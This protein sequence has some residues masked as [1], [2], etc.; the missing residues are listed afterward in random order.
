MGTFQVKVCAINNC[1]DGTWSEAFQAGIYYSPM[2]FTLSDGAGY[3]EG[4]PGIEVTLDGSETGVNYQLYRG[5]TAVGSPMA[6]TG[7]ALNFGYQ[8]EQGIYTCMGSTDHC[9]AQMV[10]NTYIYI[11]QAP[12]AAA[13]PTG[14]AQEC[15][16]NTGVAYSTAGA[17]N[18]TAY[19]WTLSP[20]AAGTITGSG[21]TATVDWADDFTGMASIAVQGINDC[22]SGPVSQN[23]QVTVG[24]TPEPAV[25]GDQ[26]VCDFDQGVMYATAEFTGNMYNW[27]VTGGTITSGAG[28]HEI[29][30]S[31]GA[32]GAG[33]VKVTEVTAEGCEA[34][35][36]LAI[37]IDDCT[38]IGE[39]AAGQ[40]KVYPN[41]AGSVLHIKTGSVAGQGT[42]VIILNAFGQQMISREVPEG[43]STMQI[44][45]GGMAPGIYTVLV[46]DAGGNCLQR[47]FVK[48]E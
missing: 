47:K 28:T 40:M 35:S 14:S 18:S 42:N 27:E 48:S 39:P 8:T 17:P 32:A 15:N 36:E 44:E 12:G 20:A 6:G 37:N 7:S 46:K 13:T 19:Q 23:L 31:W 22:G 34:S 33:S 43:T 1:G 29:Q 24:A 3:C 38:G 45:L 26:D 25:T 4:G 41:P 21:L 10:G 16:L 9:S 2:Q 30:V 11:M 5:N